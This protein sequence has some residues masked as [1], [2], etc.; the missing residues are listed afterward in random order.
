[1]KHF[2]LKNWIICCFI[3]RQYWLP[4]LHDACYWHEESQIIE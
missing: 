4:T 1:V 3:S 2:S